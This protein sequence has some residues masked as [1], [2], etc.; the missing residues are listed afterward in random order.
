M[1]DLTTS[2]SAPQTD[3]D[4]EAIFVQQIIEIRL[5]QEQM[6]RSRFEIDRLRSE[7]NA[8]K[9]EGAGIESETQAILGRLKALV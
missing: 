5:M 2:P 3:A 7:T 1:A 8:L 4:F 9:A 6:R